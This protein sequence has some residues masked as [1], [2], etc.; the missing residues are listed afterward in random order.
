MTG[1]NT[2]YL[3]RRG[4][5]LEKANW[6]QPITAIDAEGRGKERGI[7]ARIRPNALKKVSEGP[8]RQE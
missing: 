6:P 7:G 5:K 2:K 3:S 8:Q 4:A 1:E